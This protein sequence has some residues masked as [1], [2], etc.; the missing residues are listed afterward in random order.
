MVYIFPYLGFAAGE[1][2][3]KSPYMQEL[4]NSHH[5]ALETGKQLQAVCFWQELSARERVMQGTVLIC[6]QVCGQTR[7]NHP[8]TNVSHWRLYGGLYV[9]PCDCITSHEPQDVR[10]IDQTPAG[11]GSASCKLKVWAHKIYPTRLDAQGTPC[12]TLRCNEYICSVGVDALWESNTTL[13]LDMHHAKQDLQVRNFQLWFAILYRLYATC[14]E[15][16][17]KPWQNFNNS[18]RGTCTWETWV[19]PLTLNSHT[20]QQKYHSLDAVSEGW[21]ETPA[22]LSQNPLPTWLWVCVP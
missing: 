17:K 18:L 3:L 9:R 14:S 8:H 20:R 1:I 11:F 15:I 10:T 13:Y 12:E 4:S 2:G 7:A 21:K 6:I 5:Q 16:V 22:K 19:M